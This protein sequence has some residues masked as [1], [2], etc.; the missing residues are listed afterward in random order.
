MDPLWI[1]PTRSFNTEM[2]GLPGLARRQ[3]CH[4]LPI[5]GFTSNRKF[6][7]ILKVGRYTMHAASPLYFSLTISRCLPTT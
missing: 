4:A 5:I 2:S 7:L 6:G 1:R 3:G